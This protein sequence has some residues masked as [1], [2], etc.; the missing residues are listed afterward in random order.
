M[1]KDFE[2]LQEIFID[3]HK[4]EDKLNIVNVKPLEVLKKEIDSKIRFYRNKIEN[5]ENE[6]HEKKQEIN[7]LI[8]KQKEFVEQISDLKRMLED[9]DKESQELLASKVDLEKTL[10]ITKQQYEQ[11]KKYEDNLEKSI[12]EIQSL[13]KE[14]KK[15]FIDQVKMMIEVIC[16]NLYMKCDVDLDS[17]I[18]NI[19][20]E[21]NIIRDFIVLKAN[22]TFINLFKEYTKNLNIEFKFIED[23]SM[24]NGEFQMETKDFFLERFNKDI[25]KDVIEKTLQD[26]R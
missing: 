7:A 18:R 14:R 10:E 12:K 26:L 3:E 24:E 5:L 4:E 1:N 16:E 19:L 21:I 9:K 15:L 2:A 20:E 11:A 23:N 6:L 17:I 13:I 22:K 8:S 25:I